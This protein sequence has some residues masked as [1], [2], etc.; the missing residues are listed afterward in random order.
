MILKD[1]LTRHRKITWGLLVVYTILII[2]Y[3]PLAL[4]LWIIITIAKHS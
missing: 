4:L 1:E 3:W 2:V